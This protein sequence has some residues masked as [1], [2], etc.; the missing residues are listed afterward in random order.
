MFW[1]FFLEVDLEYSNSVVSNYVR[2]LYEV[3][4]SSGA[5]SE[6]HEKIVAL[7]DAM[8]EIDNCDKFLQKISMLKENSS[9]FVNFLI[10]SFQLNKEISNFLF[11]LVENKRMSLLLDVC[12]DYI[13]LMEH[14]AGKMTFYIEYA[15]ELSE[16][17]KAE[18]TNQ[19][20]NIVKKDVQCETIR[21]QSLMSGFRVRHGSKILDYSLKSCVNRLSNVIR[22]EK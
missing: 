6:V 15:G 19:L 9:A 11:I 18:I 5:L 4:H 8:N 2:S 7:R 12:N 3:S 21:D 1:A 20:R 17:K 14:Q 13:S 16:N 10:E 22:G